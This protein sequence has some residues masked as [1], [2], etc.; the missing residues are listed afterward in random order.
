L[1]KLHEPCFLGISWGIM[2]I[3]VQTSQINERL[4][5]S[6]QVLRTKLKYIR[7]HIELYFLI[8]VQISAD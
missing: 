3:I 2:A 4:L 1:S 8:F 6:T 5:S 7:K